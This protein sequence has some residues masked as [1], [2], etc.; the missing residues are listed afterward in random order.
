M[1]I[2][3]NEMNIVLRIINKE[4]I[5]VNIYDGC[6]MI[7]KYFSTVEIKTKKEIELILHKYIEDNTH[8]YIKDHWISR[9]KSY[10]RKNY[11][12]SLIQVDKI[13]IFKEELDII[14][15]VANIKIQKILF[16]FLVYAKVN[17]YL[18]NNANGWTYQSSKDIFKDA[19]VN[20][21]ERKREFLINEFVN[22]GLIKLNKVVNKNHRLPTYYR[23]SG[24]LEFEITDFNRIDIQYE[25]Y[26]GKKVKACEVCGERVEITTS[27]KYCTDCAKE[28]K[29]EKYRKYNEKRK[30]L[31]PT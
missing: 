14:K 15:A 16:S 8:K 20:M 4:D 31:P 12:K 1:Q 26:L 13:L 7:V 10:V 18:N 17:S 19:G 6:K 27:S 28:K 3:T 11:K 21:T 24:E 22:M 5:N 9:V 2:T 23:D 30:L 29:L 25:Q